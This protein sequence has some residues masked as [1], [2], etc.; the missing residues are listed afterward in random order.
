VAWW[1]RLP[2]NPL[3]YQLTATLRSHGV[4]TDN[5]AYCSGERLG[6]Y[7]VEYGTPPRG[8]K[9]WYDRANS[10][11]SQMQPSDIPDGW[12]KRGRWLHLTGITPALSPECYGTT[13][14]AMQQAQANGAT[15][16]FDVN[17]RALLWKPDAAGRQLTPFCTA[18]DVVFV[19]RRDAQNL[20]GVTGDNVED[21]ARQLQAT[22]NGTVIVTDGEDG[23][24]ATDGND[25]ASAS[26]KPA[27]IVDRIGAGDAF[28]SGVIDRLLDHTSLEEALQFGTALAA[29]KLSILG[30]IP[31]VTRDEV[32]SL[33][34]QN[35]A[36][37]HR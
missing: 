22:W 25:V 34:D 16:S 15:V 1:S 14:Y 8:I 9:V 27:Q 2:D 6:A 24:A 7:Y 13:Q 18:A 31:L 11:A 4:D 29:L 3:G 28:A 36:D 10:A 30:D 37:L 35:H 20:F 12:L 5:V 19:A 32:Q 21:V 33:L 23:C 17:Y 26:A